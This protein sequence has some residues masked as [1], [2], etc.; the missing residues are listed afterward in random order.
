MEFCIVTKLLPHVSAPRWR[1][2]RASDRLLQPEAASE[3]Q[4]PPQKKKSDFNGKIK[5]CF[6]LH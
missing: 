4:S 5:I 3:D 6:Q 1:P 2:K